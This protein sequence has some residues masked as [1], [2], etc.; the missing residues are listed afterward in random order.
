M[1]IIVVLFPKELKNRRSED[2]L[3]VW[4]SHMYLCICICKYIYHICITHDKHL[5]LSLASMCFYAR[6]IKETMY[7]T[8]FT[9]AILRKKK[10]TLYTSK[11]F[12]IK[13]YFATVIIGGGNSGNCRLPPITSIKRD[14]LPTKILAKKVQYF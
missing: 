14:F 8:K 2:F 1:L 9:E 4:F 3:Q 7:G 5:F 10:K 6:Y 11:R 13:W 12:R